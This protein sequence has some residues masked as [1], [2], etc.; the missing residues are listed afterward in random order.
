MRYDSEFKNQEVFRPSP[1]WL[2]RKD[3][4]PVAGVIYAVRYSG[5]WHI[6]SFDGV[7]FRGNGN[8][9]ICDA[10]DQERLVVLE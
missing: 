10:D 3:P 6:A 4:K 7:G 2:K 1:N 9:P 8:R 5:V